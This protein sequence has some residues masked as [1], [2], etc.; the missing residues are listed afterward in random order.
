VVLLAAVNGNTG[1]TVI[2][3]AF[4][5]TFLA[6]T[7]TTIPCERCSA[8]HSWGNYAVSFDL[9]VFTKS[10]GISSDPTAT[11]KIIKWYNDSV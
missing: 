10:G 11:M 5:I 1:I 2:A 9:T 4:S 6:R 7:E 3:S 8:V